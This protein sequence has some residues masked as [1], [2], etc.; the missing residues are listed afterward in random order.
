MNS[1]ARIK[2]NVGNFPQSPPEDLILYYWKLM[3]D[4]EITYTEYIDKTKDIRLVNY[5]QIQYIEK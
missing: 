4:G 5:E 2:T 3:C 1:F